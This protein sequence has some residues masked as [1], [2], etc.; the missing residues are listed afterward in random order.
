MQNTLNQ[1]LLRKLLQES[2]VQQA[3]Y[4]S[5]IPYIFSQVDK[6]ELAPLSGRMRLPADAQTYT[7]IELDSETG[8]PIIY[9]C[10]YQDCALYDIKTLDGIRLLLPE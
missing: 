2:L 9:D 5:R 1:N 6:L 8:H 3:A 10:D 4:D 7:F